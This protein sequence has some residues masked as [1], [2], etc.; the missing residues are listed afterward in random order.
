MR[1]FRNILNDFVQPHFA[2]ATPAEIR[3][4][5]DKLRADL[6][7]VIKNDRMYFNICFGIVVVLF[8]GSI[9]FVL[10][11]L[12]HPKEVTLAFGLTGL[13]CAALLKQIIA[14]WREQCHAEVA[15]VLASMLPPED[16]KAVISILLRAIS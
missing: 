13:S 4:A 16:L 8:L 2:D 11:N 7:G 9:A 10:G 15:F 12:S 14:L 1:S 6:Q 3:T 5:Q